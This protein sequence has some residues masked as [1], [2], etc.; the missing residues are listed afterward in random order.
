MCIRDRPVT[1]TKEY[2]ISDS[3]NEDESAV[4]ISNFVIGDNLDTE[5]SLSLIHI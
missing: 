3:E 1:V 2:A 5:L 4:L